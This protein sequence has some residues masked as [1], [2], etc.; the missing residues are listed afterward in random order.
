M[1]SAIFITRFKF[2]CK[3]LIFYRTITSK[4]CDKKQVWIIIELSNIMLKN[5]YKCLIRICLKKIMNRD[6]CR[7]T[8]HHFKWTVLQCFIFQSNGHNFGCS[9]HNIAIVT[10]LILCGMANFENFNWGSGGNTQGDNLVSG[11]HNH[12]NHYD[13]L[14]LPAHRLRHD[15]Y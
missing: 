14:R 9:V 6:L 7:K 4:N 12:H 8:Q 10:F 15:I 11:R 5:I 3:Y 2:Y 13:D 1:N